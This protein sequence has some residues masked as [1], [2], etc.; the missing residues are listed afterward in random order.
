MQ[1]KRKKMYS[2]II[3][4]YKEL[5]DLYNTYSKNSKFIIDLYGEDEYKEVIRDWFFKIL[6]QYLGKDD[7]EK[8]KLDISFTENLIVIV[9][10]K[11]LN[12]DVELVY[13]F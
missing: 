6:E 3:N 2:K 5:K 12:S 10:I 9:T 1:K 8:I 13:S 7:F 11:H 4:Y